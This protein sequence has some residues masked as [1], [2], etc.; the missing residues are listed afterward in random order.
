VTCVDRRTFLHATAVG[1]I[2]RRFGMARLWQQPLRTVGGITGSDELASLSKATA[3]INSPPLTSANTRGRVVLVQFWTF[4]CINWLR[5][6]PYV[7]AW[8][9]RYRDAGLLVIGVHTPEFTFE[10]DLENVRRATASMKVGYPVAVDNEYAIWRGFNN[11]YW[12]ALY[13]LDGAGRVR[14]H[15]FGE[16]EY[17][18][19]ERAIQQLLNQ[20]GAHVD[21]RPS[22]VEGRGIE[23]PAD[24][25][26]LRSA[27]NY[28][29]SERTEGFKSPERTA[30]GQS[31]VYTLPRALQL[32]E[33]ALQGDWTI[34][35]D[36][37]RLDRPNGAIAYRFHGRDLHLVMGPPRKAGAVRFQVLLDG[38]PAGSAHGGDVDERGNGVATEQRL[39]QLIRQPEPITDRTFQIE[40]QDAGVEAFSFT[41][42]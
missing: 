27:E 38:R 33:W 22:A 15:Q 18:A 4:T 5:T 12:P 1:L 36:R 37:V 16:G 40:F 29:G 9:E 14:H 25:A 42:G 41:F 11:Q 2:A 34:E 7:R 19:V 10:H 3:W 24:W 17:T 28:V 31:R 35:K 32:N 6:L 26:D 39:H 20:N 21:E 30:S 8:S 13:L 23:A